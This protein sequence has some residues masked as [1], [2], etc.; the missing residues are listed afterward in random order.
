MWK[1]SRMVSGGIRVSFLLLLLF[2]LF[3][4]PVT[5]LCI[6]ANTRHI[7]RA[8]PVAPSI[9]LATSEIEALAQA[10]KSRWVDRQCRRK[11][12]IEYE[13]ARRWV[14]AVKAHES[15]WRERVAVEARHDDDEVWCF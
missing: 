6:K 11:E 13:I 4:R 14:Q 5:C 2:L 15:L 1:T 10:E 12:D 9:P 3:P 8:V 7:G